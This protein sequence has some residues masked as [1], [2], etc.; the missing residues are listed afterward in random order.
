[1]ANLINSISENISEI[2]RG[3]IEHARF[4]DRASGL[5]EQYRLPAENIDDIIIE[6]LDTANSIKSNIVSIGGNVGLGSNCYLSST[7]F[8]T[9]TYGSMVVS[10][11]VTY[12]HTLGISTL[13]PTGI[14]TTQ[15]V[16]Y[17]IIKYD[18]LEAYTYPKIESL[19]V[20]TS[21]PVEGEGYVI[22]N[23]ANSGSGK[24]TLYTVSGGSTTGI[25]FS[26]SSNSPCTG[27]SIQ[28]QITPLISQYDST[29][30]GISSDTA[31]ANVVKRNKTEYQFHIWAYSRKIKENEDFIGFQTSVIDTLNNSKYG[32]PY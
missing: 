12:G 6:T 7:N 28:N 2:Q 25:V 21:N 17:G 31:A 24:D 15:N 16:G 13:G 9:T 23:S 26:I 32:G 27:A 1:M 8:V 22:L 3:N 4:R 19:D 10:T 20:S 18:K 11:G 14:G 30:L 29:I 5:Y